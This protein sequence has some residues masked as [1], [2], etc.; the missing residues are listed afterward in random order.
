MIIKTGSQLSPEVSIL[1]NEVPVNYASITSAEILLDENKHDVCVLLLSGIPPRAITDY[2]DAPIRVF[3]TTGQNRSQEF[4]GYITFVEPVSN[5][6]QP[7]VNGSPFQVTKVVALGTSLVMKGAKNRVWE[8]ATITT[9]AQDLSKSYGFSLDVPKDS[10]SEL[11]IA[12]TSESDW[13]FITRVATERGYRVTVHGTHMHIWDPFKSIGRLIS[14]NQLSTART[15]LSNAPGLIMHLEGTFGYLT[16]EGASTN[17]KTASLDRFGN[18]L[19]V[20]SEE[21]ARNSWSGAGH[22]SKFFNEVND[23][24][25][26]IEQ[27]TRKM[28]AK[29]K[30]TY[31]FNAHVSVSD[32]LGMLPGGIVDLLEYNANFDGLWYIQSVQHKIKRSSY[33]TELHIARD[34]NTTKEFVTP[35]VSSY[36][37]PPPPSFLS[38]AWKAEE[39]RVN[40]Y[41]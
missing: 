10:Y 16:P 8:N 41:V 4:C 26:N 19:N 7:I 31:A 1:I 17:Y 25:D 15:N 22:S 27:A 5:T 2:I 6:A 21:L 3:A 33:I 12:Q 13:S 34:F 40:I 38:G 24:V 23:V 28:S 39:R 35:P 32:G 11:F 30:G 29:K 14:Y 9:I 36:E 20:R 18:I 37:Q